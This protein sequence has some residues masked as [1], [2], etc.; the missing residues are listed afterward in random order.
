MTQQSSC[1]TCGRPVV[2]GRREDRHDK[3]CPPLDA[4]T[5]HSGSFIDDEGVAR[6]VTIYQTHRCEP[7]DIETWIAVLAAR[8]QARER[9]EEAILVGRFA[10]SEPS[11]DATLLDVPEDLEFDMEKYEYYPGGNLPPGVVCIDF[12]CPTCEAESGDPCWSRA[13]TYVNKGEKKPIKGPHELRVFLAGLQ[14]QYVAGEFV[15]QYE[16]FAKR[17]GI[18]IQQYL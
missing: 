10:Q 16:A 5:A 12:D 17:N 11:P 9:K 4:A 14:Q 1:G 8:A 15:E 7:A 6:Q 3:F 2:W 18:D 13:L